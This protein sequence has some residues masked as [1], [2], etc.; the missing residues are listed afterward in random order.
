[1][2][3]EKKATFGE[4][5]RKVREAL[6]LTRGE[7]AALAR[8]SDGTIK[9]I[10]FGREG[11]GRFSALQV[12]SAVAKRDQKRARWVAEAAD[13]PPRA[14]EVVEL[15]VAGPVAPPVVGA[16]L[17]IVRRGRRKDITIR[18]DW[19]ATAKLI[20]YLAWQDLQSPDSYGLAVAIS[21]AVPD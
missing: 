13:A 21:V 17:L 19:D 6:G 4:R 5:L 8:V 18:L 9:S 20:E 11:A 15:G 16:R 1:M 7:L 10:E 3:N 12:L 14:L 2:M